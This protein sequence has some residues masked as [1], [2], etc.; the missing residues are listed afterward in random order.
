MNTIKK[1]LME[2]EK[3]QMVVT[4]KEHSLYHMNTGKINNNKK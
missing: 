3:I 4:S 1:F 2:N